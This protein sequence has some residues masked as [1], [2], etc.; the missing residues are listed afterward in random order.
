V[1]VFIYIEKLDWYE[2]LSEVQDTNLRFALFYEKLQSLISQVVPLKLLIENIQ[3]R[4][5]RL[6]V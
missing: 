4:N 2:V 3:V 5:L 6:L 1:A